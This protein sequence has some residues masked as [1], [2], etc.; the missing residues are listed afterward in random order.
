MS[1]HVSGRRRIVVDF[2]SVWSSHALIFDMG[3][4]APGNVFYLA[5]SDLVGSRSQSPFPVFYHTSHLLERPRVAS[6]LLVFALD[7]HLHQIVLHSVYRRLP[8]PFVPR[9]C[10]LLPPNNRKVHD[11]GDGTLSS[12][13]QVSHTQS[14][15]LLHGLL[16]TQ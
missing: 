16:C 10:A 9:S 15:Q 8:S 2:L 11:Q 6:L 13:S 1:V 4:G 3:G 7:V 14:V 12:V 5:P